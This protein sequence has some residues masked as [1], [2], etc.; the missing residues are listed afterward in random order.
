MYISNPKPPMSVFAYNKDTYSK[1][2]NPINFV[3][4]YYGENNFLHQY[5]LKRDIPFTIFGD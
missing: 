5:A 1:I 2:G 3:N 4:K